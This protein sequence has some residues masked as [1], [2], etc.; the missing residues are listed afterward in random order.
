MGKDTELR[1]TELTTGK[2]TELRDTGFKYSRVKISRCFYLENKESKDMIPL[3]YSWNITS[4]HCSFSS[5]QFHVTS[6]F[7]HIILKEGL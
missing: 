6:G 3:V 5:A 2:T 1:G 4:C 7:N